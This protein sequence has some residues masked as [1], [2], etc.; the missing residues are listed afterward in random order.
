MAGSQGSVPLDDTLELLAS[1]HRRRILGYLLDE[2]EPPATLYDLAAKL[3][4]A[5][6]WEIELLRSQLSHNHLPRLADAGII[7]YDPQSRRLQLTEAAEEL[8]PLLEVCEE[9]ETARN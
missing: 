4:A 8:R 6:D 7:E 5:E 3:A 9:L 2:P 1:P